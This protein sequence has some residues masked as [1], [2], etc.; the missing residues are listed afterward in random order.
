MKRFVKTLALIAVLA[1]VLTVSVFAADFEHCADALKE[2]GLFQGT[3]QGYELDRA[4][5]RAEAGVMLVLSLI[6]I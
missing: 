2:L 5:N 3:S 6:H 1:A 4:P